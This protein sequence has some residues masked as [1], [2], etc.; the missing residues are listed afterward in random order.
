MSDTA[1]RIV[2]DAAYLIHYVITG[3]NDTPKIKSKLY[4]AANLAEF[5]SK[6]Y[7]FEEMLR[8]SSTF[9][10]AAFPDIFRPRFKFLT[11]EKQ[12]C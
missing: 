3:F 1:N 7:I 6:F 8:N 11:D 10:I 2:L 12:I 4:G 9:I 5:K